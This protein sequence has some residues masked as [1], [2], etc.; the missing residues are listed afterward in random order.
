MDINRETDW[1][2]WF[3]RFVLFVSFFLLLTVSM[4]LSLVKARYYRALARDNKVN[5]VKIPAARGKIYDRKGRLMVESVY[6]YF[7][8]IDG[9]KIYDDVGQF[10]GLRFEGKDLAY[11]LKRKYLYG[12]GM[13]FVTGYIGELGDEKREITKEKCNKEVKVGD[14]VGRDG[15]EE[16][17]D[18]GLRGTDG[19]RLIEVDAKGEYVRELGRIDPEIGSELNL[20]LDAFW[21][22]RIY[23]LLDG[24]KAVVILSEPKT[25]RIISM[26]SSPAFDPNLFSFE[27]DNKKIKELLADDENWPMLNRAISAKYQPGSVFKMVVAVAGLESE[28]IDENTLIEDTGVIKVGDYS[29]SNWLWIKRGGTEGQ[30]GVVKAIKRSND[31]FFYRLGEKVGVDG[32]KVWANK[33]GFGEK[34]GIE[35]LGELEGIV[36]DEEWKEK[37][38]GEK[39][40]LGNTYHLAIGQGDL[41]VTPLQI[42]QMTNVLANEGKKCDVSLQG[43]GNINCVDLGIKKENLD[44]VVEGMK[45]ACKEGGTAWP[46]FN[47]KTELAC[48]T[49]T[50]QVGDGTDDTHAWLTA[51]GPVNDAE[52]SITVIVERGGE[53][54]DV[55]APIVGDILKEWFEEP[56][57]KVP[58]YGEDGKVVYE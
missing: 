7:H 19:K 21:Q 8:F 9:A 2:Y 27:K 16:F 5:E 12:E 18:C 45:Q 58:R 38:K 34:S 4:T 29:Y 22:N 53:G 32:I 37:N 42:N 15:V 48:K 36:P 3:F 11:E 26:V 40:Y 24:R 23:E 30:V 10:E 46:L 33:F 20:S 39:W 6:Q 13:A 43:N 57:T 56:E 49:G 28:K 25:G 55:A 35:L 1:Q 41:V 47:F 17:F 14:M 31:I 52:I 44:L 54:S 50:A 51:F